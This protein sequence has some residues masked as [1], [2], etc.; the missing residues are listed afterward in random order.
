VLCEAVRPQLLASLSVDGDVWGV[1]Q[2][3][4]KIYVVCQPVTIRV[5][6]ASPPYD[7]LPDVKVEGME[8]PWDIAACSVSQHLYI[9]DM[10]AGCVWRTEVGGL[11]DRW[12]R[13]IAVDNPSSLSVTSGRLLVVRY[14]KELVQY[15]DTPDQ[16]KHIPLPDYMDPLHA[17]ETSH[18]TFIVC[19][20]GRPGDDQHDQVSEVD[21]DGR[22]VR[23]YGGQ[24]GHGLHQLDYPRHLA[25]D[26][27]GRLLVADCNNGRIVLL[28]SQ[29][30]LDRVLLDY[31]DLPWRLSYVE[32]TG[33]LGVGEYIGS[34]VKVYS[35]K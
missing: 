32:G 33:Q 13:Y 26:A 23:V 19:H 34:C 17:V 11:V 12:T 25:Q 22:V 14:N 30:E 4:N 29:L 27:A 15:G 6:A 31:V 5:Y 20:T 35:V 28:N 21:V 9:A 3:A 2:L 16:P 24:R 1:A 10:V 18:G 7:R 8:N